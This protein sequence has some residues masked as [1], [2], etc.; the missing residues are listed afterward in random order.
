IFVL[1]APQG[2]KGLFPGFFAC[3]E[4]G[5]NDYTSGLNLDLGPAPTKELSVLNVESAG[6]TGFRDL[7]IPGQNLAA[8][9]PFGGFHVFTIR[10]Q[11]KPGGTEVWLD[12]IKL[13][14]RDR[15]ES[16]IG[17]DKVVLG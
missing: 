7:L 9:L 6:C 17:L 10:S 2:N 4:A 16:M 15:L 14:S 12:G 1:A 13:A 3:A 8:D 11:I 5:K